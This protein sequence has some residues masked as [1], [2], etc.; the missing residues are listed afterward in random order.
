[1]TIEGIKVTLRWGTAGFGLLAAV[2]WA[3]ASFSNVPPR[4]DDEATPMDLAQGIQVTTIHNSGKRTDVLAT[5]RRQTFW[6]GWAAL[7]ASIA[8]GCQVVAQFLE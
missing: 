8:A 7:A 1:M 5:A 4:E 3:I 6:N 2:L